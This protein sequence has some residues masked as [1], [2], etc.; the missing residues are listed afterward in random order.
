MPRIDD[1]KQ[2][3]EIGR[4]ELVGKNP[5]LVA[6]LSGAK[7]TRHREGDIALS[8]LFLNEGINISWP[9]IEFTCED[10]NKEL[11][12]QQ[13]ILILHYFLGAWR[14]NGP[15]I[16]GQWC[17]FQDIPDGRFY[18]DAFVKR[19]KAPLLKAFGTCPERLVE[20]AKRLYGAEPFDHGD[21][22]VKV[23]AF[24]LVRVALIIWKGDEEFPPEG[25][26]LFD[27]NISQL[28]S[29]EDIAWLAGMIVYP[30]MGSAG[31]GT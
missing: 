9:K 5:D 27:R 13:Q 21:I 18:L 29:A 3:L 17:G 7:V 20:A 10:S 4:R 23:K 22:S 25:N 12:I 16:T 14:A 28:L 19:A 6:S 11:S 2:A 26:I 30:L 8:L 24:P 15:G 1:Y 31:G